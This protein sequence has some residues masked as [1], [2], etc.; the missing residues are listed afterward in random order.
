MTP[1]KSGLEGGFLS[2]PFALRGLG[3]FAGLVLV[4]AFAE[5]LFEFLGDQIDGGV[6]ITFGIFGIEIG[7]WH[8][9]AHGTGELLFGSAFAVQFECDA[10]INGAMVEV[11][12]FFDPRH[13]MIFDGFGECQVMGRQNQFHGMELGVVRIENPVKGQGLAEP[14]ELAIQSWEPPTVN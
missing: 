1:E 14:Q 8:G 3:M 2:P 10:D 13:E 5:L 4:M 9:Q 11:I 12:E 6:E 7:S